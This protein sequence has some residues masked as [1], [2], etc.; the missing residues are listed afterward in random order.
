MTQKI[1]YVAWFLVSILAVLVILFIRHRR[2]S[3]WEIKL[4]EVFNLALSIFG[5]ISGVYINIS[6]IVTLR[7]TSATC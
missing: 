4:D 5:G 3:K 7:Y 2:T 6:N 1:L